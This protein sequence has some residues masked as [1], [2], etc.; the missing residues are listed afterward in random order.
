MSEPIIITKALTKVYGKKVAVDHLTMS[1]DEGEIFGLLGPNGAGKTTTLLMLLGL[2]VPTSGTATVCGYDVVK[3]SRDVRKVVGALP[4]FAGLYE[5]MTARENLLYIA[6][7]NGIPKR[8]AEERIMALLETVDLVSESDTKVGKFSRG[9]RQRLGI[10]Q[11]LI[12]DPR[13]L[14]LDEPTI[15]VDP[16]GT[17]E[18]RE[19]IL[20]LNRERKLTVITSSHLLYEVQQ[21]CTR[22][23]IMRQGKMVAMDTIDNLSKNISEKEGMRLEIKVDRMPPELKMDIEGIPGVVSVDLISDRIF[24][25][26]V[27]DVSGEVSKSITRHGCNILLMRSNEHPLEEIFMKYY[28]E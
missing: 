5:D 23:G 11:A 6:A 17:K 26:M 4:E 14:L 20:R 9:M 28:G 12:K 24:V 7:L 27:R 2:T 25:Q 21:F 16:R 3:N 18:I 1:V 22:V 19:L 13:V 8:S 10:A 15:G